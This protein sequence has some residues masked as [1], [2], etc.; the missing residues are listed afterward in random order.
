[1][2]N[3][4]TFSVVARCPR[5]G[6]LGV[7]VATAVP[8]VGALCPFA[9]A[10][11]GA[12]CSQSWTNPYLGIDGLKL[13]A[14]GVNAEQTLQRLLDADPGRDGRQLGVVDK[15][16][17][18]AAWTGK[19]CDDWAGHLTGPGFAAQGNMLVNQATVQALADAFRQTERL[20]LAERL[21]A[22]LEAAQAAG[23]DKRG[24]QS[25]ALL[26]VHREEYPYLSL[27]VDEHRLP[28]NELRRVFEVARQQLVPW[29]DQR[30]TRA[31][32]LGR[33]TEQ[34]VGMLRLPPPFRPGGGGG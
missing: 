30:P 31:E 15:D 27:R 7:A 12:V 9:R 10:G 20:T 25:A 11:A 19:D 23:G 33:M 34:T 5:S 26:V 2:L 1:M 28:I 18:S 13:L 16:G 4:N 32:P 17:A 3:A 24:K 22:A 21:L 8:A 14:E 29:L 6:M